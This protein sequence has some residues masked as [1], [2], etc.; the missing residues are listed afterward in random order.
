[1]R[2]IY[3]FTLIELLVVIAIIGILVAVVLGSLNDARERSL[4]TKV[5]SELAVLVK[6]AQV[7]ESKT[8]S[9]DMTC[10]SNG[11]ATSTEIVN[12]ITSVELL[13]PESVVCNSS[14]EAFAVSAAV[15]SSSYWCVDSTG[16]SKSVSAQLDASIPELVCP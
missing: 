4:E 3:G 6:R 1:M 10:G 2:K 8:F 5:K 13:S 14:N 7:E 15:A 12:I 16:V 9:F 11:V